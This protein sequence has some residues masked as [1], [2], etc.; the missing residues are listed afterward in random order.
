[1]KYLKPLFKYNVLLFLLSSYSCSTKSDCSSV[2]VTQP[3]KVW[4]VPLNTD[5]LQ[6]MNFKERK[7]TVLKVVSKRINLENIRAG[8]DGN[9]IRVWFWGEDL[10]I[11]NIKQNE[12]TKT[13]DA[14]GYI[15][16][17]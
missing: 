7:D 10:W 2:N 8:Y 11:V 12:C 13:C 15:E 3:N 1:M 14:L 6:R 16:S 17:K 9:F 5:A 4:R